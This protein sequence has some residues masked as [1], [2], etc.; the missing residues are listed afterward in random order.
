[1]RSVASHSSYGIGETC[2]TIYPRTRSYSRK[3]TKSSWQLYP[4]ARGYWTTHIHLHTYQ[5]VWCLYSFWKGKWIM[6]IMHLD[7]DTLTWHWQKTAPYCQE[8]GNKQRVRCEWDD[9]DLAENLRNQTTLYDF[10]AISLPSYRGCPHVKRIEHWKFIKFEV[11]NHLLYCIGSCWWITYDRAS[12]LWWQSF[13]WHLSCGD[14]EN[15]H[16][17]NIKSLH[18]G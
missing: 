2:T 3:H 8:F 6:F 17:N 16:E 15:L 13:R 9:P 5:R 7:D 10:D 4:F 12:T 18:K 14:K 1:M 11:W